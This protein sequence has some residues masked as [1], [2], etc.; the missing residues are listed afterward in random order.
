MAGRVALPA[1]GPRGRRRPC[2]RLLL[3]RARHRRVRRFIIGASGAAAPMP[4]I[5]PAPKA[6]PTTP[7]TK[8]ADTAEG[9]VDEKHLADLLAQTAA[10]EGTGWRGGV[11]GTAGAMM[12]NANAAN[13][14]RGAASPTTALEVAGGA[15]SPGDAG[16][17]DSGGRSSPRSPRP[18]PPSRELR[19]TAQTPHHDSWSVTNV[20]TVVGTHTWRINQFSLLND[21]PGAHY[22]NAP[23]V[24]H[25]CALVC[26]LLH[27][28][29]S[30][31]RPCCGKLTVLWLSCVSAG[32]AWA[33]LSGSFA[34]ARGGTRTPTPT[35]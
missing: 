9:A 10:A 25:C 32:S 22:F 33:S 2:A 3:R 26:P 24:K 12:M 28:W 23:P 11:S 5:A 16:Y 15:R 6:S 19:R 13:A 27:V 1:V 31:P 8:P 17:A 20:A 21:K 35:R 4:P 29:R 30:F 34:C 14:P 18:A 7:A